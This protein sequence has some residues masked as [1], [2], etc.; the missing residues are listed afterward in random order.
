[1]LIQ[2]FLEECCCAPLPRFMHTDTPIA[3][4]PLQPFETIASLYTDAPLQ[5]Y[6][7][8]DTSVVAAQQ[9]NLLK[10]L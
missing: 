5:D 9:W 7:C 10:L 8:Y 1:M 6:I 2:K 4:F 3:A